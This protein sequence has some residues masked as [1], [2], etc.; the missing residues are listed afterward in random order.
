[1]LRC[2]QCSSPPCVT[3][4]PVSALAKRPDGVIDVDPGRCIGCKACMQGCPY[5]ALYLNEATGTAQKCHF[6][7]HRTERGLAPACAVVCPTE[8]IIPG[9]F[10]DP[11]SVVSNLRREYDLAGRKVEAG[12]GPN[13]FYREAAPAGLDPGLTNAAGGFLWANPLSG[14]RADVEAFEA[15]EAKARARTTYDVPHPLQWG[16]RV[17]DYVFTKSLAAGVWLVAVLVL[18]P[19]RS[20]GLVLS[21]TAASLLALGATSALLVL[22]L[23]R[24]A[25]FWYLLRYP[26]WSSWL[27]RGAVVLGLYGALLALVAALALAGVRSAVFDVVTAAGAVFAAAYTGWLFHQAKG[28]VLWLRRGLAG[29]LVVHAMVAGAAVWCLYPLL[30]RGLGG[31]EAV[32]AALPGRAR[33]ALAAALLLHAG[34]ILLEGVRAPRGR[35]AEYARAHRL[36]THGPFARRHWGVGVA[37]GIALPL[38]L[39]A[40]SG[41]GAALAVAGVLALTGLG[42]E[43]GILVRAGQALP[44]S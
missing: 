13:V 35:R 1:V 12:T 32:P 9:D 23:K 40:I 10:H 26:N 34:L 27:V 36:V 14:L 20:P 25:R 7:V 33:A 38:L 31:T 3:I 2:N 17:S 30:A 37:L 15:A 22:D 39:L 29:D 41:G 24:P 16:R 6:C 44:I 43:A 8:A 11:D 18:W 19:L 5:D 28:R 21:A 42:V 4:C